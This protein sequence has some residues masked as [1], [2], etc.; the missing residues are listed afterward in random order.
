MDTNTTAAPYTTS[1]EHLKE[2]MKWLEG[3]MALPDLARTFHLSPFE[4][5]CLVLCLAPEVDRKYAQPSIGQAIELLCNS[6]EEAIAAR[7]AFD[8]GAPLIRGRLIRIAEGPSTLLG[9][10]L[11]LDDRIAEL[12]LGSSSVA[13]ALQG[14]AELVFPIA[15]RLANPEHP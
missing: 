11:K 6:P 2:E 5:R 14:A 7:A 9:R 15:D 13:P 3:H 4:E 10:T 1:W 12:L 8:P